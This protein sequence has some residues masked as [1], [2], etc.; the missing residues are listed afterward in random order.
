MNR[1]RKTISVD[2]E[3]SRKNCIA[4]DSEISS[5]GG[6]ISDF[7]L[8]FFVKCLQCVEVNVIICM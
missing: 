7:T 6:V 1:H 3:I 8:F 4:A 2:L 5:D